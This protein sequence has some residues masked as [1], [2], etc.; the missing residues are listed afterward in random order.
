[1]SLDGAGAAHFKLQL[2]DYSPDTYATVTG[3]SHLMDVLDFLRLLSE[4]R[5]SNAHLF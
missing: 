3:L 4:G 5:S 2:S 1:M